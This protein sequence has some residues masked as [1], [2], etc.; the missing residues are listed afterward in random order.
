[1]G[2]LRP[3]ADHFSTPAPALVSVVV[4]THRRPQTLRQALVSISGQRGVE[5]E[6]L[7]VD[8]SPDG[9]ADRVVSE[10][11]DERIRLIHNGGGTGAGS[12]R[13]VG[14]AAAQGAYVAFCDDDDL[15][16]PD[17]LA[18][19][20]QA[21]RQEG[22][23]WSC[24]GAVT[25]DEHLRPIGFERLPV[26]GDRRLRW[27]NVV[28][29]GGSSVVAS[30][31]ELRAAGGFDE[32]LSNAED[33]E[34]WIRLSA[35]GRIAPV[36]RPLVAY[37][38]WTGSKSTRVD[39]V[40]RST[41]TVLQR[42]GGWPP[43]QPLAYDYDWYR[44]WKVVRSGRRLSA[45]SRSLQLAVRHR[46]PRSILRAGMLVVSPRLVMEANHRRRLAELPVEWQV[47]IASWLPD[48]STEVGAR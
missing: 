36:D 43:P 7:V 28:P 24:T 30:T 27:W 19:Q 47:D 14:L 45:A 6:V 29:G 31:D 8:D 12:S 15:W 37:R 48:L 38:Q 22:A 26:D 32:T 41:T 18:S 35:R 4:P 3:M 2:N 20:L 21:L 23:V 5:M 39:G 9:S 16:A 33:W 11:G 46:H 40:L 34:A 25:V 17:K 10:I 42:H 44:M 13:N 1:M